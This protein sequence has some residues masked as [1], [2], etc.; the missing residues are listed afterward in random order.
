MAGIFN[1]LI[2]LIF[3]SVVIVVSL[4]GALVLFIPYLFLTFAGAAK[5]QEKADENLSTV[6]MDTEVIASKAT[7]TR[8]FSL[9]S[10]RTLVAIT[11]SR[12]LVLQRGIFG[13]FK[14]QDIQWKDLEDATLKQNILSGMCGS[15][16]G[17]AHLNDAVG[18]MSVK[19]LPNREATEMYA[20][21]QAEEQAWEE[22]RRVR[23]I[24]EVR[25][26]SGAMTIHTGQQT[27]GSESPAPRAADDML[28][29]IEDAKKL[30]DQGIINDVEFQEMKSKIIS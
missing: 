7:Q 23:E 20:K 19:G 16:V 1:G 24:E 21:A 18:S 15:N 30:L 2:W 10:R 27:T 12:L 22:K 4:G 26:A 3:W 17:F 29:Q 6:L 9:W 11:N 8:I 25:A 13:G 28:K 5:R 14:M